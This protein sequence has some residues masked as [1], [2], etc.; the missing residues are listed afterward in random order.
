MKRLINRVPTGAVPATDAETYRVLLGRA[1]RRTGAVDPESLVRH[2]LSITAEADWPVK[3]EAFEALLRRLMSAKAD[4]VEIVVGPRGGQVVGAYAT[5]RS[6]SAA[7][8]YRT[9]LRALE[10]VEGSCECA[11]FVRSSLGLCKHLFAVLEAVTS[12]PRA[13][14][15]IERKPS[16]RPSPLR[17]DPVRPLTG[18]GDWLA[19]VRWIDGRPGRGLKRWLRPARAGGF[20]I[21]VPE[22][23]AHRVKPVNELLDAL[24][25]PAA[26]PALHAVLQEDRRR[27]M[28]VIQ[29]ARDVVRLRGALQTLKQ[30]LYPYQRQAVT[31]FL[32]S[33]RLLLADDMGLGK[34]AQAI[35]AC[36]V[37]WRS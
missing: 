7:R 32:A 24:R 11:D 23:P 31:R 36:H 17:W 1:Q 14:E 19:Q 6:D 21:R 37:L 9:L 22:R 35:V 13:L 29:G 10:P 12:R 2:V 27:T 15:R 26:E 3:Y 30:R 4:G 28:R 20:A 16:A 5:R 25:A 18:R 8:S 33:G 34:T